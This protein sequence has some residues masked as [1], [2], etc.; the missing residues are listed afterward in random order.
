M[1][2]LSLQ[3]LVQKFIETK[4][5]HILK[6]GNH[7]WNNRLFDPFH[8]FQM[9]YN[10]NNICIINDEIIDYYF[11]RKECFTCTGPWPIRPMEC[12]SDKNFCHMNFRYHKQKGSKPRKIIETLFSKDQPLSIY[13]GRAL[14]VANYF[15]QLP[16][17]FRTTKSN[18]S[19]LHHRVRPNNI[20]DE[21]NDEIGGHTLVYNK[22]HTQKHTLHRNYYKN[23]L[24][25]FNSGSIDYIELTVDETRRLKRKAD[26]II[27][28]LTNNSILIE[29]IYSLNLNRR[30]MVKDNKC[31]HQDCI[32]GVIL[33][34]IACPECNRVDDNWYRRI[35]GIV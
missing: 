33:G 20:L 9:D 5:N 6:H 1:E 19:I 26:M 28:S 3:N 14:L 32:N 27:S 21:F 18:H 23:L 15:Y 25:A 29:F 34:N 22:D 16:F 35:A 12:Y 10:P 4:E 17:I 8:L 13:M 31:T 7:S 11:P 24:K 30:I 2:K